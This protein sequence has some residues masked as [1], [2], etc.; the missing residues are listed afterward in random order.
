MEQYVCK[1]FFMQ[2]IMMTYD[3]CIDTKGKKCKEVN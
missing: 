3:V 1:S 2:K